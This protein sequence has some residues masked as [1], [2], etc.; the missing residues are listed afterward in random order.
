MIVLHI[1]NDYSG[2]K[3]HANLYQALET[4]GI[5]QIVYCPVR[6]SFLIGKNK[7]ASNSVFFIYSFCIKHWYKYFYYYKTRRL[8]QDLKNHVDLSRIDIIHATTLFSDGSLAY[9]AFKEYGIP[10]IVAIRNTDLNPYISSLWHTH[11]R[12]RKILLNASKIIF[13]S[14]SL[15]QTFLQ[16]KFSKLICPA[17]ISKVIIQTNGI[18]DY[19]IK[20]VS[21]NKHSGHV[22]LYVGQF[23]QRK[24]LCRLIKA[25]GEVRKENGYEDT[26]LIVVGGGHDKSKA[27]EKCIKNNSAF[28]NYYGRIDD[29]PKICKIMSSC[30]VFAMPS[31]QE[32]FGL[33]YIE[34]LSQNLPVIFSKGQGID[35]LFDDNVGIAVNPFSIDEIKSAILLILSHQDQYNNHHICF[36]D[37]NW[38]A[39]AKRY[40]VLYD[41]ILKNRST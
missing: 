21:Y 12:G 39:I 18:D 38:N 29:R 7:F 30:S 26:R 5:E 10:Y 28:V 16:T 41:E 11:V 15:R 34:A 22:V 27:A 8:Y 6:D 25:V 9:N 19:W 32:T 35:G 4:L 37:F 23:F 36:E 40:K 17:I 13:I 33:V 20:N 31:T 14:A 1:C 2:S 3:V 24:N